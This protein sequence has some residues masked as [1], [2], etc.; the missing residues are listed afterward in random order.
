MTKNDPA[1][2]PVEGSRLMTDGELDRGGSADAIRSAA[3]E[4]ARQ[5]PDRFQDA[6]DTLGTTAERLRSEDEQTLVAAYAAGLGLTL[7]LLFAGSNRLFVL[8]ALGPTAYLG[9]ALL[10]RLRGR[11]AYSGKNL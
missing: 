10:G 4:F 7:G 11:G 9:A 3:T 8:L 1:M 6:V 2:D 5:A